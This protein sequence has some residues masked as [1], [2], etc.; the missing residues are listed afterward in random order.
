M[1]GPIGLANLV[2]L[3][4]RKNA[5][6]SNWDFGRKKTE[7]FQRGGVAPF[8]LTAQVLNE[9]DWTPVVLERRQK[10]LVDSLRKEWRL[11]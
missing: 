7:Y 9:S 3:S 10:K 8:A 6:A 1:R 2:L 5:S 4:R 11:A